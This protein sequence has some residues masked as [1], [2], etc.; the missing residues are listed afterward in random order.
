M[1]F[2]FIFCTIKYFVHYAFP[3]LTPH[4][5]NSQHGLHV[6]MCLM[7]PCSHL[8]YLDSYPH[9]LLLSEPCQLL[10]ISFSSSH[11]TIK[12]LFPKDCSHSSHLAVFGGTPW[13]GTQP[14]SSCHSRLAIWS[15]FLIRSL[16]PFTNQMNSVTVYDLQLLMLVYISECPAPHPQHP[17]LSV[18]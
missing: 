17:I 13:A 9:H 5:N 14:N 15:N 8:D 2:L 7:S 3:D 12:W 16:F 1:K 11:V 6:L 18:V 10:V 4:P